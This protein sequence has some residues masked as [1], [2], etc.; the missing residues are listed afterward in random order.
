[1][2]FSLNHKLGQMTR[3]ARDL[4]E[5][6]GFNRLALFLYPNTEDILWTSLTQDTSDDIIRLFELIS[7][8]TK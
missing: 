4:P 6:T 2:I 5:L 3:S 8:Q 7:Y 1:M